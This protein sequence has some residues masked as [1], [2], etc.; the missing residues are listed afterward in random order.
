MSA[1]RLICFK[2]I[3]PADGSV[4]SSDSLVGNTFST[5]NGPDASSQ[6]PVASS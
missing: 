1:Y 2:T 6:K 3:S 4:I 5:P